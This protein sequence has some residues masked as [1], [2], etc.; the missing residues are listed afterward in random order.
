MGNILS[1]SKPQN[2]TV[3]LLGDDYTTQLYCN[4]SCKT[5][6]VNVIFKPPALVEI[7]KGV[8]VE[9]LGLTLPV[10]ESTEVHG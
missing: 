2:Y 4:A 3:K 9:P 7:V 1:L 10:S 8:A 5:L 6:G